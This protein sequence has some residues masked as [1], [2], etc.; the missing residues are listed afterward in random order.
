MSTTHNRYRTRILQVQL[1]IQS[2]LDE[3]L[4]LERL[5]E[6]AGYSSCHFHRVFR[7]VVGESTDDYVRR[8]RLER[9]A[10][11]LRYRRRNILEVALDTGYSS[12]EAFTRAFVRMFGVTPSEYQS[13]RHPPSSIK[14]NL[15]STPNYTATDVRI[16]QMPSRRMAYMRVVG[17]YNHENLNPAFGRVIEWAAQ[18]GV[19]NANTICL[20]VYYDDPEVTAPEKQ[21]ADVGITV[22]ESFQPTG[23]IHVQTLAGGLCAVLRHQGHYETL[24]DAYRWFYGVWL[25]ESGREPGTAPPYEIYVNDAS[26]LPPEEWLTDICVPLAE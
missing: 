14:E 25:P 2:R 18:N 13:L 3:D 6:V 26:E 10:Q 21:R 4:T 7:G 16:E 8:L 15:M 22:D 12:H 5:A 1:F 11:S 24:G 9:A 20:G 19:M 23:D 17:Q